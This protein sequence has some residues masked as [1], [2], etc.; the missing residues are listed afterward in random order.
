MRSKLSSLQLALKLC[1][2]KNPFAQQNLNIVGVASEATHERILKKVS[3]EEKWAFLNMWVFL[4]PSMKI[5]LLPVN[6]STPKP[7]RLCDVNQSGSHDYFPY[8][9]IH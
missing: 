6:Y 8:M 3:A 7:I 1:L 9:K 2:S 4:K 5:I